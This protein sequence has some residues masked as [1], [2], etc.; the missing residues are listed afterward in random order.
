MPAPI[1]ER[2]WKLSTHIP[3]VCRQKVEHTESWTTYA[4]LSTH[5]CS[6]SALELRNPSTGQS[7]K[8]ELDFG[9]SV[10]VGEEIAMPNGKTYRVS[11]LLSYSFEDRKFIPGRPTPVTIYA[12]VQE[13]IRS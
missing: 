10:S 6:N 12:E 4:G 5:S 11:K 3:L 1:T 8:I 13:M 7:G 9:V 2:Q